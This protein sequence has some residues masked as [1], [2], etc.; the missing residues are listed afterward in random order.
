MG[1]ETSVDKTFRAKVFLLLKLVNKHTD[2]LETLI[3][4]KF[5]IAIIA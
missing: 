2:E 5:E 1:G 4:E 3:V